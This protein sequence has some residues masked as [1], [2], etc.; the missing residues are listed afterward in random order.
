MQHPK[1]LV[2][3]KTI[4]LNGIFEYMYIKQQR[5]PFYK[6]KGFL[7]P[8][9]SILV[10][11]IVVLAAF[12]LSPVPGALVIRAV[13]ED[14]GKKVT[15]SLETHLPN[16]PVNVVSDQQYKSGD[17][18]AYLDVY[19]SKALADTDEKQPVIIWTHGGAWLSG[20]KKNAAPY[21]KLLASA[22]YTV[23]APNYSLAP[24]KTYPTAVHQLND[25]Y[26]YIQDNGQRFHADTDNIVFAGD[27]AGSQL[28]AQLA[29]ITTDPAYASAMNMTP[30]LKPEQ[31]K[32]VVL[33]C[34]IYKMDGLTQPDP[35]LPKLVGWGN[36]VAV[37]AL[38]GTRDF[39]DPVIKQ[40]SPYYH[41]TEDF[42]PTFITGGNNDA[43]TN[44]QSKPFAEKLQSLNVD[45]TTLFY[46]ANHQPGLA[47]EYQF[48][49]STNDGKA[50][51]TQILDFVKMHVR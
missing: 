20:D 7:W 45:V 8:V 34:G 50:A 42:P 2:Y 17:N 36:D 35:S 6:K 47:H 24:E 19:Y 4:S 16:K 29:A 46:A 39:S 41:V 26:K 21:F 9:G 31:L 15:Q 5:T 38:T 23:I 49:L 22:G 37:W 32:G 14:D 44:E 10:L 18:D 48:D 11:I 28:S 30:A 40:M 25:A 27:S 3:L 51:L 12:R 13:F 43:L 1:T 33:N